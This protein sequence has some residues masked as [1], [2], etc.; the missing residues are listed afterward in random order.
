[1]SC[2]VRI[3]FVHPCSSSL[4]PVTVIHW[5]IHE[6][7]RLCTLLNL[8]PLKRK[9]EREEELPSP[10][11]F[12]GKY[13]NHHGTMSRTV[14]CSLTYFVSHTPSFCTK[15]SSV[16]TRHKGHKRF[17]IIDSSHPASRRHL[18]DVPSFVQLGPLFLRQRAPWRIIVCTSTNF[19]CTLFQVIQDPLYSFFVRGRVPRWQWNPRDLVRKKKKKS[20][21]GEKG[22]PVKRSSETFRKDKH[23]EETVLLL[24]NHWT[25]REGLGLGDLRRLLL[26]I[27]SYPS[28]TSLQ[29]YGSNL[30]VLVDS[31]YPDTSFSS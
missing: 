6:H 25:P 5:S 17:C 30:V 9:I 14:S 22:G 27:Q 11:Q 4:Y 20:K 1:M 26:L 23:G 3:E 13:P 16:L 8:Y 21:R 12:S 2:T 28:T 31:S 18:Y 15:G 19:I 24:P 7:H 29:P 10:I